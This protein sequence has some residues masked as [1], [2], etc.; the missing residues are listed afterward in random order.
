MEFMSGSLKLK[1]HIAIDPEANG[2]DKLKI[3]CLGTTK[4]FTTITKNIAS[5]P[6]ANDFKYLLV[7]D[8]ASITSVV[9]T[10]KIA[11]CDVTGYD[12]RI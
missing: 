10:C 1:F 9:D 2:H 8:L 11:N 12:C 3:E 6:K 5:R 7:S 4:P